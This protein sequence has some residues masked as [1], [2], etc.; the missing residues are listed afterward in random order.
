MSN[1]NLDL[2]LD[3]LLIILKIHEVLKQMIIGDCIFILDIISN[4]KYSE[5]LNAQVFE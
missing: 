4:Y 2:V 3:L 1:T 5:G